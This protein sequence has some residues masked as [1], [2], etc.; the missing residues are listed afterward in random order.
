[1]ELS[2]QACSFEQF[3]ALV[4][5]YLDKK[6][7]DIDS[8]LC[9]IRTQGYIKKQKMTAN[10]KA[11]T[12]ICNKALEAAKNSAL[13]NEQFRE[14]VIR[15]LAN[16]GIQISI[17]Q[18]INAELKAFYYEPL[19]KNKKEELDDAR[20]K[21]DEIKLELRMRYPEEVAA[22]EKEQEHEAQMEMYKRQAVEFS[23]MIEAQKEAIRE[24]QKE[25]EM[26]QREN[27]S[28][29]REYASRA[30][31]QARYEHYGKGFI[32]GEAGAVS[33]EARMKEIEAK[34]LANK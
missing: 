6:K 7:A 5:T 21:T 12:E 25:K 27:E 11:V 30:Q 23:Q 9:V 19:L 26:K 14:P 8:I 4:E 18:D 34:L 2:Y 33:N 1:M 28:L 20:R 32:T 16:N 29:A 15:Y 31:R 3:Y 13:N 17:N 22:V 10:I 24:N